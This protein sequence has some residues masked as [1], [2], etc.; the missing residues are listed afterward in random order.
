MCDRGEIAPLLGCGL[1]TLHIVMQ[2]TQETPSI[3]LTQKIQGIS[4]SDSTSRSQMHTLCHNIHSI[5]TTDTYEK[6]YSCT[7]K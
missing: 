4:E 6:D 2:H 1:T 5:E 7:D 3:P